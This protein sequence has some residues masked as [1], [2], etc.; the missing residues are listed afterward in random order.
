M[1]FSYGLEAL[2]TV[3]ECTKKICSTDYLPGI[4]PHITNAC[5]VVKILY[6]YIQRKFRSIPLSILPPPW[7]FQGLCMIVET[8]ISCD[9]F[10]TFIHFRI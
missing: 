9:S 7:P 4:I 1:L 2:T 8:K 10:H 6:L 5:Q 3:G